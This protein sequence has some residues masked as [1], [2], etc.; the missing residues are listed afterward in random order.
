M[1]GKESPDPQ[2]NTILEINLDCD[3]K[4]I[5]KPVSETGDDIVLNLLDP[6]ST[7]KSICQLTN[8]REQQAKS[9]KE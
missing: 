7:L 3:D 1:S 2:L 9:K 5:M 8:V 6:A 4:V